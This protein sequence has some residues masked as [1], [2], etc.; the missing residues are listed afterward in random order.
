LWFHPGDD[1]EF[2]VVRWQGKAMGRYTIEARFSALTFTSTDVH[3]L[4]NDAPLMD[5]VI[6][7]RGV[8]HDV[9][10]RNLTCGPNDAIDFA[11][12]VGADRDNQLDITGLDARI[13]SMRSGP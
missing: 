4:H 13:A 7:G 9:L 12:G 5:G 8:W 6:D 11:V 2:S 10:I 1:G 3:L